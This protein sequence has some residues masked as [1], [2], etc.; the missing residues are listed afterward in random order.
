MV[1]RRW[2]DNRGRLMVGWLRGRVIFRNWCWVKHRERYS[3]RGRFMVS[4]YRG[5]GRLMVSDSGWLMHWMGW[6]WVISRSRGS[7]YL[8]LRQ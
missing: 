2:V 7:N 6:C 1:R 8:G 3:W 4:S 5:W